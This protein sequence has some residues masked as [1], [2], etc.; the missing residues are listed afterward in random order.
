MWPPYV[1]A[2]ARLPYYQMCI[3]MMLPLHWKCIS[4]A[5]YFYTMCMSRLHPLSLIGCA[6]YRMHTI[7]TT[8]AVM[9]FTQVVSPLSKMSTSSVFIDFTGCIRRVSTLSSQAL[10]MQCPHHLHRSCSSDVS[11]TIAFKYWCK[12]CLYI[13]HRILTRHVLITFTVLV[14]VVSQ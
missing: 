3:T 13:L 4:V 5:F 8:G 2:Y 6:K 11:I 14:W 12:W 10:F 1:M 9:G 7:N